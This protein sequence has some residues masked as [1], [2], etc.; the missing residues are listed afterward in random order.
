MDFK[1][2]KIDIKVRSGFERLRIWVDQHFTTTKLDWWPLSPVKR[3][4]PRGQG[5]L[6]WILSF[7]RFQQNQEK[8]LISIVLLQYGG[9]RMSIILDPDAT[10]RWNNGLTSSSSSST[11]LPFWRSPQSTT[12]VGTS[13][14][15]AT[16]TTNQ[17]KASRISTWL[18]KTSKFWIRSAT[19]AG[20]QTAISKPPTTPSVSNCWKE[21]YLCVDRCWTS[22][23][24]TK[25]TT[26]VSIDSMADDY[27]LFTEARRVLSCARGNRLQRIF[28][29]RSYT[30]VSL[31]QVRSPPFALS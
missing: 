28:S 21:S 16:S 20:G 7:W 27:A 13:L 5:K 9:R 22:A 10:K 2:Y 18:S 19:G 29:W 31:S 11:G 14:S 15:S 26:I 6:T 4:L 3:Q 17:S 1:C 30:R 8:M 12:A 23:T 24:E 25:L